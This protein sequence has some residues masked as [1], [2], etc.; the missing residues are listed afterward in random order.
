MTTFH[1]ASDGLVSSNLFWVVEPVFIYSPDSYFRMG[2]AIDPVGL[3]STVR[4]F[5]FGVVDS[6]PHLSAGSRMVSLVADSYSLRLA[7]FT[8]RHAARRTIGSWSEGSSGFQ[9]TTLGAASIS[10]ILDRLPLVEAYWRAKSTAGVRSCGVR[11]RAPHTGAVNVLPGTLRTH[12]LV[13]LGGVTP[14]DV[15]SVAGVFVLRELYHA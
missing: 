10:P 11:S 14:P 5:V 1:R 9:F 2:L 13:S 4:S 15:R 3:F 7:R 8:V 12:R 6:A